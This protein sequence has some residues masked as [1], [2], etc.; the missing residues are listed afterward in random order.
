MDPHLQ[1]VDASG[2]TGS[3]GWRVRKY[4]HSL[5]RLGLV[6]SEE[7]QALGYSIPELAQIAGV[8]PQTIS[9]IEGIV[10][11]VG[12]GDVS[13]VLTALGVKPLAL[14]GELIQPKQS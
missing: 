6:V 2:A 8:R 10:P 9:D 1:S 12:L 11:Q 5:D 13:K 4:L 14:P 7:R 3:G